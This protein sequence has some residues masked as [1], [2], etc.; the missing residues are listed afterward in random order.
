MVLD[1]TNNQLL[2]TKGE[3]GYMRLTAVANS[4]GF[5]LMTVDEITWSQLFFQNQIYIVSF[6]EGGQ[7]EE[8]VSLLLTF[9]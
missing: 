3:A 5:V 7:L 8:F 6:Y 1:Y 4:L 2:Y 9:S